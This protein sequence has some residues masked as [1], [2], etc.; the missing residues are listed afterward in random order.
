MPTLTITVLSLKVRSGKSK[1]IPLDPEALHWSPLLTSVQEGAQETTGTEGETETDSEGEGEE[2]GK[3]SESGAQDEGGEGATQRKRTRQ[4]MRNQKQP[5][6]SRSRTS[7]GR[8][9]GERRSRRRAGNFVDP[10]STRTRS[11]NSITTEKGKFFALGINMFEPIRRRRKKST[12]TTSC[13]GAED[14]AVVDTTFSKHQ[15]IVS[16]PIQRTRRGRTRVVIRPVVHKPPASS[17]DE[18]EPRVAV[19]WTNSTRKKAAISDDSDTNTSNNSDSDSSSSSDSSSGRDSSPQPTEEEKEEEEEEEEEEEGRETTASP[20][21]SGS[22]GKMDSQS[23]DEEEEREGYASDVEEFDSQSDSEATRSPDDEHLQV[24]LNI[25]AGSRLARET[26]GDEGEEEVMEEEDQRPEEEEDNKSEVMDAAPQSA[27]S[28]N[29]SS[30]SPTITVT[31]SPPDPSSS[32]GDLPSA[33]SPETQPSPN[34]SSLVSSHSTPALFMGLP[35]LNPL[36][37][38]HGNPRTLSTGSLNQLPSETAVTSASS[39]QITP[40]TTTSALP[41]TPFMPSLVSLPLLQHFYQ[42]AHHRRA[43]TPEPSSNL[44][45]FSSPQQGQGT[46]DTQ[47]SSTLPPPSLSSE[48]TS[49]QQGRGVGS[50]SSLSSMYSIPTTQQLSHNMLQYL[51]RARSQGMLSTQSAATFPFP[52]TQFPIPYL[53]QYQV[54]YRTSGLPQLTP[55][56]SH[57]RPASTSGG[58]T[59]QSYTWSSIDPPPLTGQPLTSVSG[60]EQ[61]SAPPSLQHLTGSTQ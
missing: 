40:P 1:R 7:G 13:S 28:S 6:Q 14:S 12:G 51:L 48:G 31:V 58:P 60:Q 52:S 22:E 36:A 20:D 15:A 34:Y 61:Q 50:Q 45:S 44:S 18:D 42:T 43:F 10:I 26:M 19:P 32:Q 55:I 5:I 41:S 37:Q 4:H 39:L 23:V 8:K 11:Q 21:P 29:R 33:A 9:V 24:S 57:L 35:T 3:A 46:S 53:T 30:H 59:G 27:H 49:P 54:P 38:V 17:S 2:S 56:A 47:A 16:V 25:P